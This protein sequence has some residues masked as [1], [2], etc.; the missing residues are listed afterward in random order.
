MPTRENSQEISLR[1]PRV[2]HGLLELIAK[3]RRSREMQPPADPA[4][5]VLI[6]SADSTAAALL[7]GLVE[8]LGYRV[9]FAT[10]PTIPEAIV[11]RIRPRVYLLDCATPDACSDATIGRAMMRGVSV[12]L[13]GPRSL[14]AGM[15][16]LI[17]HHGVETVFM[18]PDP[19]PLGD[20]LDRAVRRSAPNVGPGRETSR[21]PKTSRGD[22]P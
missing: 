5:T 2:V 19:G 20:V 16:E 12:V 3:V 6:V 9:A 13:I 8:T 17:A 21:A 15:R 1:Q 4:T 11:Q 14:L 7:G 18:P 10:L 22:R